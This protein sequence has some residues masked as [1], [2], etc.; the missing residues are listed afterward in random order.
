MAGITDQS[1]AAVTLW[2]IKA[3]GNSLDGSIDQIEMD[4]RGIISLLYQLVPHRETRANIT[5]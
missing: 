1:K 5:R 3:S 2:T 4:R